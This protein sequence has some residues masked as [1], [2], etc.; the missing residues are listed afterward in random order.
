M[1]NLRM[2]ALAAGAALLLGSWTAA[3]ASAA[4]HKLRIETQSHVPTTSSTPAWL[5]LNLHGSIGTYAEPDCHIEAPGRFLNNEANKVVFEGTEEFVD[6]ECVGGSIVGSPG[7]IQMAFSSGLLTVNHM[8]ITL[9]AEGCVYA[10]TTKLKLELAFPETEATQGVEIKMKLNKTLSHPTEERECPI[11]S[12]HAGEEGPVVEL[13]QV[14]VS[15]EQEP[16]PSNPF[17][18]TPVAATA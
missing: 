12:P 10:L 18:I 15:A 2:F 8:K 4:K 9:D 7:K 13:E 14:G 6:T 11:P 17:V 1:P 3:G 16:F 5:Q